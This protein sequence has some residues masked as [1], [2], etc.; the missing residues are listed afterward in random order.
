MRTEQKEMKALD[1][2]RLKKSWQPLAF[3]KNSPR[4]LREKAGPYLRIV[5]ATGEIRLSGHAFAQRGARDDASRFACRTPE[6][7]AGG[8]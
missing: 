1:S 8:C 5:P 4:P 7:F 3:L 2:R 6:S